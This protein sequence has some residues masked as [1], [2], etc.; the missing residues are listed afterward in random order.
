ME[1]EHRVKPVRTLLIPAALTTAV[2]SA[3]VGSFTARQLGVAI[4]AA[5]LLGFPTGMLAAR[6]A[7]KWFLVPLVF[8]GSA[9]AG[10]ALVTFAVPSPT[11][12]RDAFSTFLTVGLP[13]AGLNELSIIPFL[14]LLPVAMLAVWAGALPRTG[15]SIA[16][17]AGGVGVAVALTGEGGASLWVVVVVVV[18][19][20]VLLTLAYDARI[21]SANLPPLEGSA[22][23][24]RRRSRPSLAISQ[25]LIVAVVGPVSLSFVQGWSTLN[26][27]DLYEPG[28]N[29][30]EAPS[31]LSVVTQWRSL[32][33]EGVQFP[34]VSVEVDGPSPGRLRVAVL[35]RYSVTGW[36]QASTYVRTGNRLAEDPVLRGYAETSAQQP[37][38]V[39]I[40]PLT[41]ESVFRT[42]PTAG[43]P[44][45]VENPLN[46]L[47]SG[48]G[49]LLFPVND[50]AEVVYE[51]LRFDS[52]SL[53]DEER[54]QRDVPP[55]L[56]E[57]PSPIL[58]QAASVIVEG[59]T[60]DFK[61]LD[62][63]KGFFLGNRRFFD[64][65]ALGGQTLASVER[66]VEVDGARGNLE[67]YVTATALLARCAGVPVRVSV[68]FPSPAGDGTTEYQKTDVTAWIEVPFSEFGWRAF[69]PLPT[70]EE[71]ERQIQ[72][73]TE[74]PP[75]EVADEP[76][77]TEE[78]DEP[79]EVAPLAAAPDDGSLLRP[80]V[81]ATLA[82]VAL[83]AVLWV[84]LI[85]RLILGLRRRVPDPTQAVQF[86]WESALEEL[87]RIGVPISPQH[88][89]T[90][91]VRVSVGHAPMTV[92]RL[93]GEFA[94]LVDDARYSGRG[95]SPESAGMAWAL[96][97]EV[98][99]RLGRRSFRS[100][101]DVPR[102]V[103]QFK[104]LIS[105][106]RMPRQR[107]AWD[108]ALPTS[109]QMRSDEA[110]SDLPGISIEAMIGEGSTG[111]VFRG[112]LTDSGNQVAVKVF[113]F[114]PGDDGFDR[115]RFDW[116]VRIAEQVS[117]LAHLPRIFS[118][119]ISPVSERPYIVATLYEKGT[120]LDRVRKGGPL[121][122]D[123][124]I[125]IGV[126]ISVALVALH[127]LGV[128]HADIKPEN[129]FAGPDGWVLGDLGSAWLRTARGPASR[130]TPPYAAPE[131]W[132]G[133]NPSTVADLYSLALTL[134]F[135]VT[136]S[137]PIAGAPPDAEELNSLF[138][139]YPVVIRALEIDPRRR[140]RLASDFLKGLLP[141]NQIFDENWGN[142]NLPTPT[143]SITQR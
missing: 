73:L 100:N 124:A 6:Y 30:V 9:V 37:S 18:V 121:Q 68:G 114:G 142:V 98:C 82:A 10:I 99:K 138:H 75:P 58:R 64:P 133:S 34:Y 47:F 96:S 129:I 72:R 81:V 91:V 119:G 54:A 3:F 55:S 89:P 39:R 14:V 61:K 127:Q 57:C 117:G 50:E 17:A 110:P 95:S 5:A 40:R 132:R 51:T 59:E 32:S 102:L 7:L 109:V 107:D 44:L 83:L 15:L 136:G 25:V 108:A 35:N 115:Q 71:Q 60:S 116:E 63:V 2:A 141:A 92:P 80:V 105:A 41:D 33:R 78:V 24:A 28:T 122:L 93:L 79:I 27:R 74:P 140:P 88:T 43:F 36:Q 94:P 84:L 103:R 85:P 131:V 90:E 62:R 77:E 12:I 8:L 111:T 19:V 22:T 137:V 70:P 21:D 143:I 113:R 45:S 1:R 11:L 48:R 66:F 126:E 139:D 112:I 46:V 56:L 23:E 4:I 123:D 87:V 38:I 49:G 106:I 134:F 76:E 101:V 128:V 31:P 67:V 65:E 130:I 52:N 120:L 135:S 104:F 53:L 16:L 69:D 29:S 13:A 86:A 20:V 125:D 26:V 97:T 118:A 42:A